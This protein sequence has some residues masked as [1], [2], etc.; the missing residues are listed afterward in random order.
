M[1][2][3]RYLGGADQIPK[4]MHLPLLLAYSGSGKLSKRHSDQYGFPAFPITWNSPDLIVDSAFREGCYL[5]E[6]L[7]KFFSL[8]GWNP[9][10][11]QDIFTKQASI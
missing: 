3:C 1:L 8:L 9:G 10:T 11:R 6:A 7:L 2:F 4:F 5:P